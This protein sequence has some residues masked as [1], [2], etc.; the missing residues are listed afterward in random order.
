MH[1]LSYTASAVCLIGLAAAEISAP[2][3]TPTGALIDPKTHKPVIMGAP[4]QLIQFDKPKGLDLNYWA[5]LNG[6]CKKTFNT[7]WAHTGPPLKCKFKDEW[8]VLKY[9]VSNCSVDFRDAHS[10][11]FTTNHLVFTPLLHLRQ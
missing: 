8:R 10:Q 2:V 6:Y 3:A 7:L 9:S 1:F 4:I 5:A 11:L